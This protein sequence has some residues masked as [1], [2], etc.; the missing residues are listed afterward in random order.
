MGIS[1]SPGFFILPVK[2]N[3]FVPLLFS[4]PSFEYQSA[5]LVRIIGTLPKVS[6]LFKTVGL[7][8]NPASTDWGGLVR[9]MPRF[10]SIEYCS[11]V[12][13]PQTN[14]PAPSLSKIVR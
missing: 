8:H 11:A 12:D 1:I 6:T 14:A 10:P 4:V 5:P 2:E 3:I 9:G 7:S 13:S